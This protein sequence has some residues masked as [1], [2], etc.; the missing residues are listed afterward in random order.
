[1]RVTIII[2]CAV[3]VTSFGPLAPSV[4]VAQNVAQPAQ[5]VQNPAEF[6]PA[7][8]TGKQY[9]DSRGCIF[10]RAGIDGNV[11]WVPRVTRNRKAICGYKPTFPTD[12][13]T[14]AVAAPVQVTPAARATVKPVT[15]K[16]TAAKPTP[17]KPAGSTR[18]A[19]VQVRTSRTATAAPLNSNPVKPKAATVPVAPVVRIG[20]NTR[21]VPRHVYE[22]R[23]NTLIA[24]VPH[25]YRPAW[26]DGRLNPHRAE[27][28]A[29]PNTPRS[30]QALPRRYKVAWDDGR[31]NRNR[32]VGTA[33]G[34][35]QTDLIWQRTLP[36]RLRRIPVDD[37]QVV[38]MPSMVT[39][40]VPRARTPSRVT[41]ASAAAQSVKPRYVRVAAFETDD[42]ARSVARTLARSGLPVR[43]GKL[44]RRD[45]TYAMVLA[46]PFTSRDD[47]DV[48]LARVRRAG[49]PRARVLN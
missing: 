40:G 36:R 31:L 45:G 46:G 34:D 1:M 32:G 17:A 10:I 41:R 37:T 42:G 30:V 6:P 29:A 43:L 4:A 8:F 3:F 13:A 5:E 7:S 12:T 38:Q 33:A 28:T 9:V 2:A 22:N 16:P 21:I 24:T 25:G 44:V 14:A 48:A 47:A 15:A 20:S 18:P 19:V 23:Q 39:A 26:E 27:R 49:Y 35:A 11:A